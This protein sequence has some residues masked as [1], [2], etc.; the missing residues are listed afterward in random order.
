M[1][2]ILADPEPAINGYDSAFAATHSRGNIL[3]WKIRLRKQVNDLANLVFGQHTTFSSHR[4]V[5]LHI[6]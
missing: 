1:I 2:V 5:D 4:L 6:S 3:V